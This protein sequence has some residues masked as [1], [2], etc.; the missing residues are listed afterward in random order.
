MPFVLSHH[1]DKEK[2]QLGAI[3]TQENLGSEYDAI[4]YFR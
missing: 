1:E 2:S 3:R 4:V